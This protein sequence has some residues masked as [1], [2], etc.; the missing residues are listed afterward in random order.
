[1]AAQCISYGILL[2]PEKIRENGKKSFLI[3]TV[4]NS[5]QTWQILSKCGKI[6]I[7]LS[8]KVRESNV[9]TAENTRVDLMKSFMGDSKIFIFPHCV[10]ATT[11]R[12]SFNRVS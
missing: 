2:S 6:K 9:F 8:T 11:C 12:R 1:M 10:V 3:T 5:N 7:L 4:R